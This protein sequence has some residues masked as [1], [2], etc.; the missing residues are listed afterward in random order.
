MV[1]VEGDGSGNFT[2]VW[3]QN[4]RS[5]GEESNFRHSNWKKE[6]VLP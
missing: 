2:K 6:K 5:S 1:A 4:I 3:N